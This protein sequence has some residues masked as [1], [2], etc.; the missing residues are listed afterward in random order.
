MM[1]F[2]S[3]FR[4]ILAYIDP[5]I[6]STALQAVFVFLFGALAAYFV[7][8]WKWIAAVFRRGKAAPTS[9]GDAGEAKASARND[10]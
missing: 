7:G 10:E 5:G 8:P 4:P 6:L 2:N 1:Q 3:F 9:Q